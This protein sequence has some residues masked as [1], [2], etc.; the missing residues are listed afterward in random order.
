MN[1]I[2]FDHVVYF[3]L[4]FFIKNYIECRVFIKF[5]FNN[6]FE[7]IRE[8]YANYQKTSD[9]LTKLIET[10]VS[11][12]GVVALWGDCTLIPAYWGS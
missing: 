3:V 2:E 10:K 4:N 1:I 6:K 5:V 7:P 12:L 9:L 11:L 8:K